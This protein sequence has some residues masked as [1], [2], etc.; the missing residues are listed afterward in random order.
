MKILVRSAVYEICWSRE[1]PSLRKVTA[2]LPPGVSL[3]NP[4]AKAEFR[5]VIHELGLDIHSSGA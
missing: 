2:K 4:T 1:Y 3:R 5:A